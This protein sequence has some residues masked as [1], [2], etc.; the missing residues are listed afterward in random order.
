M[1]GVDGASSSS[2]IMAATL[3]TATATPLKRLDSATQMDTTTTSSAPATIAGGSTVAATTACERP[4]GSDDIGDGSGGGATGLTAENRPFAHLGGGSAPN[5]P[6]L[7]SPPLN[8]LSKFK[9]TTNLSSLFHHS[10]TNQSVDSK[11]V[12]STIPMH[13]PTLDTYQMLILRYLT[14][15]G[16]YQE[17]RESDI[18]FFLFE[19][20]LNLFS[21]FIAL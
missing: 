9:N 11:Y 5:S 1:S 12:R 10:D 3:T 19:Y 6:E 20:F 14:S 17:V 16:E 18:H 2:A 21:V 13:P 7:K 4:V 8:G 15:M